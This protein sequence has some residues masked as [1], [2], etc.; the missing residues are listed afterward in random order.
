MRQLK[1]LRI[2]IVANLSCV[3]KLRR[4]D[5]DNLA[6]I[7]LAQHSVSKRA[8]KYQLLLFISVLVQM[9]TQHCIYRCYFRGRYSIYDVVF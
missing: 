3:A 5:K 9:I 2:K 8:F 1:R 7:L 6:V 4:Y